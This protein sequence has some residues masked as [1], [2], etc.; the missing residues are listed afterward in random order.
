MLISKLEFT[1]EPS[2]QIVKVDAGEVYTPFWREKFLEVIREQ[3]NYDQRKHLIIVS[4][5]DHPVELETLD[6][7]YMQAHGW[8]RGLPKTG[9]ITLEPTH[10]SRKNSLMEAVLINVVIHAFYTP[11]L[12]ALKD[13][14]LHLILSQLVVGLLGTILT[15]FIR[16]RF[17]NA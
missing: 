5:Q 16:R 3:P 8:H 2:I 10:Q 12:L 13:P 7:E 11:L 9:Y 1:N 14:T 4:F 15:Y 17:E 6:V